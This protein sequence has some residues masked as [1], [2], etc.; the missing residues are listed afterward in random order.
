[1]C[2]LGCGC[3]LRTRRSSNHTACADGISNPKNELRSAPPSASETGF[4]PNNAGESPAEATGEISSGRS[5][6]I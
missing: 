6:G 2:G 3:S 1:M 5:N 4:R